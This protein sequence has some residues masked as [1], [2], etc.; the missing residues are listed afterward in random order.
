M[1][2]YIVY[3]CLTHVR[4]FQHILA[5]YF[6][7]DQTRVQ[8]QQRGPSCR[9]WRP[10]AAVRHSSAVFSVWLSQS[11]LP[12][13]PGLVQNKVWIY[14]RLAKKCVQFSARDSKMSIHVHTGKI[15][16]ESGSKN[17]IEFPR[18][19]ETFWRI[20]RGVETESSMI[21]NVCFDYGTGVYHLENLQ[22]CQYA[23]K[24]WGF[25]QI[26]AGCTPGRWAKAQYSYYKCHKAPGPWHRFQ[27][28]NCLRG[29]VILSL[30]RVYQW[31]YSNFHHEAPKDWE[32]PAWR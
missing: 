18:G 27:N 9:P 32:R 20:P 28:A 23:P 29:I 3:L 17:L 11:Q 14:L 24:F 21:F 13:W 12:E 19:V 7:G 1:S 10:S 4:S 5:P 26:F 25:R 16:Q 8:Q 6:A 2:L 31:D 22:S 30:W 15:W